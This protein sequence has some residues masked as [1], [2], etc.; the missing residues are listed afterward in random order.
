MLGVDTVVIG[1]PALSPLSRY[2]C[3]Q[4]GCRQHHMILLC[5]RDHGGLDAQLGTSVQ[6]HTFTLAASSRQRA[7]CNLL[8]VWVSHVTPLRPCF[9]ASARE[10]VCRATDCGGT[11]LHQSAN[12]FHVQRLKGGPR[13]AAW[14][15]LYADN[16][17]IHAALT[18]VRLS[19]GANFVEM[20][21]S[22]SV[23]SFE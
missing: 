22:S 20:L 8:D 18:N 17:I 12:L 1:S 6:S 14:Q 2:P 21:L 3:W 23:Q 5:W 19:L 4:A 16:C 9:V 10:S 11:K 15:Y 13:L 7:C